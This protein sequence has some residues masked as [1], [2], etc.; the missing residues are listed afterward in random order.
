MNAEEVYNVLVSK[1]KDYFD[2]HNFKKAVIGL[3]GGVDSSVTAHLAV[4]ALGNENVTVLLMPDLEVTSKQTIEDS[5]KVVE[6]LKIKHYDIHISD[7]VNNFKNLNKE[8][9]LKE[10]VHAIANV[11]ARARMI[12]LY[13]FANISNA[14]VIGTSDKSEIMLGY[15]TK[16]GDNASDILAVGDLWKTE[17]TELGR[18]LGV[19]D[20]ILNKKPTAELVHGQT[21]EADL[22]APYEVLDKMLKLHFEEK[23]SMKE[24]IEKGFDKELVENAFERME[25]HGHKSTVPELI[26]VS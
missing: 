14:L 23:F 13:Y 26:K 2:K 24:I 25:I 3:S 7:F 5:K 22:G 19:P 16:Y 8:L 9:N 6:Q 10:D 15:A 11:K 18:Y 1:I 17:V 4:K 20:S 12:L 21:D